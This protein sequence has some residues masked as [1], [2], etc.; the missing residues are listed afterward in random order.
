MTPLEQTIFTV[1]LMYISYWAG[2]R[3]LKRVVS[4]STM[5]ILELVE[6]GILDSISKNHLTKEQAKKVGKE[7]EKH[8]TGKSSSTE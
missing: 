2:S 4:V 7:I 8:V 6:K 5:V 1:A 3:K